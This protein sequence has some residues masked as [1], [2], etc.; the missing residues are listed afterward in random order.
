MTGGL[1][2]LQETDEWVGVVGENI[3]TETRDESVGEMLE[4]WLKMVD[5]LELFKVVFKLNVLTDRLEP[6]FFPISPYAPTC[7]IIITNCSCKLVKIKI[8]S[9]T[10]HDTCSVCSEIITCICVCLW[11]GE[12]CEADLSQDTTPCSKNTAFSIW[13]TWSRPETVTHY[14]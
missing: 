13:K 12:W 8:C 7:F 11:D 14:L 6:P 5:P 1:Q 4:N 10:R 9:Y 2:G 3:L